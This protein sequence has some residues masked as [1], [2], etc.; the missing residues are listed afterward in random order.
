M[1]G[2]YARR[3]VRILAYNPGHDGAIA[4][5]E[6]GRLI[7][8]IESEKDS[9]YR[10][11]PVSIPQVF[12][13]ID[14]FEPRPNVVCAG[15]WWQGGRQEYPNGSSDNAGYRG[16][17]N[18]DIVVRKGRF[19]R[20]RIDYFSSSHERSHVIGA[21]GLSPLPKGT[22]C[23]VLVW[24]GRIGAFY[25]IDSALNVSLLADVMDQP[26]NR[27]AQL[28]GWADASFSN[29]NFPPRHSDAGKLMAL[30]SSTGHAHSSRAGA[31]SVLA[32]RPATAMELGRAAARSALPR[33]GVGGSGVQ[34][35]CGHT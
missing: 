7:L 24:E 26:G 33:C 25:A 30:V 10:Y 20:G 18:G 8:S 21:F 14:G 13:S 27:Y 17:S 22:P 23:Y 5:I 15:G 2:L 6:D 34:K 19:S 29:Y 32:G 16:V 31:P 12:E 3:V 4:F 28:Y 11:T 35:F 1:G 9:N